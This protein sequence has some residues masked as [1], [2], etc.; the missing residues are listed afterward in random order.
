MQTLFLNMIYA[1]RLSI[2]SEKPGKVKREGA[3][4]GYR[5]DVKERSQHDDDCDDLEHGPRR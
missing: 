4:L 1:P 5:L 3:S 2:Y